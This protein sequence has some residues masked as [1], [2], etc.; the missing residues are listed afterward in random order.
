MRFY[1]H[2]AFSKSERR[3][4]VVLL[5]VIL[6]LAFALDRKKG[7]ADVLAGKEKTPPASSPSS[8]NLPQEDSEA[9]SLFAFNPNT[10]D[11]ATLRS[12]GLSP[13]VSSNIVKYRRAGGRFRQSADLR[14]IYGMDSVAFARIQPYIYIPKE[15][16]PVPPV[17]SRFG[18]E[19]KP[20]DGNAA[21]PDS[22]ALRLVEEEVII[23]YKAYMENKLAAGSFLDLNEADSADLVRIP[24]IGPYFA[25]SIINLRRQLGGFVS[26]S[27]LND[28]EGIPDIGDWVYI[29]PDVQQRINVNTASLRTLT[30]HPYIGYYRARAI[31]D[32][33]RRDGRVVNMRQLYFLDEFSASDTLRL[34]PYLTFE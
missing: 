32:I 5:A 24:G 34:A 10:A 12:L 2:L 13:F 27:Q 20:Q 29:V 19:A 15:E 1:D 31:M 28:I 11:S 22:S 14:K 30:R 7:D 26:T 23:P 16:S 21:I 3:A 8:K 25:C 33:R 18:R 4:I 17:S 9:S 6:I